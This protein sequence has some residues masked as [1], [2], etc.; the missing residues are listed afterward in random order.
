MTRG[1]R[2]YI[3]VKFLKYVELWNDYKNQG[4]AHHQPSWNFGASNQSQPEQ[5]NNQNY[6][7]DGNSNMY[8]PLSQY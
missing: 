2:W 5:K 1:L 4:F 3:P 6:L 8:V 7:E